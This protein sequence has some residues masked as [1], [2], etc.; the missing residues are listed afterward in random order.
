MNPGIQEV[1]VS[2]PLKQGLKHEELRLSILLRKFGLSQLSIK[3]RIETRLWIQAPASR[4][5]VWVSYPLKQGLKQW[6][7]GIPQTQIRRLSQL[8]IKTRIETRRARERLPKASR[9]LSQLSIKTRIETICFLKMGTS[10]FTRLSQLSIKTRIET[11]FLISTP[12]QDVHVWVSYPLKQGLKHMNDC[13]KR[14][15]HRVW[16]S[17][18]LKQGL[19]L[20]VVSILISHIRQFESAIH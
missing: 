17:Y 5:F 16:V 19:K 15:L 11:H 1:W 2:Y 6:I 7:E 20:I 10:L 9:R 13:T 3:T 12:M 8:S 18:P 4:I 14:L